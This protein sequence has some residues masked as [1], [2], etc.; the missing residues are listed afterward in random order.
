MSG[1]CSVQIRGVGGGVP[2]RSREFCPGLRGF[3][4]SGRRGAEVPSGSIQQ[5]G[6]THPT[7]MLSC[8]VFYLRGGKDNN[9]KRV[10]GW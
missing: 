7:G 1:G 8:L 10:V 6:G 5:V 3:H 2:S 4:L 9:P